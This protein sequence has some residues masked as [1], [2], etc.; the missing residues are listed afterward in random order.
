[1]LELHQRAAWIANGPNVAWHHFLRSRYTGRRPA[2]DGMT[3]VAVVIQT[4]VQ[5]SESHAD[6]GGWMEYF[7]DPSLPIVFEFTGTLQLETREFSIHEPHSNQPERTYSGQ[8]SENGRVMTLRA[9]L[10]GSGAA[11]PFHLIH[12]G[13]LAELS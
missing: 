7:S 2:R 5:Q 11:K 8:L 13:T 1:M 6:L 12:E 3:G 9:L 4:I 10:P